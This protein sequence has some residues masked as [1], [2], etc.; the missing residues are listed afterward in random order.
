M[1]ERRSIEG[2][3]ELLARLGA[4]L[5]EDPWR[6]LRGEAARRAL[7]ARAA[8][9]VVLEGALD[10][11][12]TGFALDGVELVGIPAGL[13]GIEGL[14]HRVEGWLRPAGGAGV[15]LEVFA[16]EAMRVSRTTRLAGRDARS[17]RSAV[18]SEHADETQAWVDALQ[19]S[20]DEREAAAFVS[21]TSRDAEE[22]L[23]EVRATWMRFLGVDRAEAPFL[24]WDD[25]PP[26]EAF[27]CE[28]DRRPLDRGFTSLLG[29]IDR[30]LAEANARVP[31]RNGVPL[32]GC[33]LVLDPAA[34][35]LRLIR[36]GTHRVLVVRG[37]HVEIVAWE[38][39]T[40]TTIE[41]AFPP[42]A[43]LFLVARPGGQGDPAALEDAA[44][45][46]DP[47]AL[48]L[49]LA[50][51]SA[52]GKRSPWALFWLGPRAPAI[53]RKRAP[54]P[55]ISVFAKRDA[56]VREGV[57]PK[58][59]GRL[60]PDEA[61]ALR[62]EV[63]ATIEGSYADAGHFEAPRF[64]GIHLDDLRGALPLED[65][66]S[67]RV[68]GW[69][70]PGSPYSYPTMIPHVIEA[71]HPMSRMESE[72]VP[73]S[74]HESAA[75][76]PSMNA[77]PG[78]RRRAHA[79]LRFH[80]ALEAGGRGLQH[81]DFVSARPGGFMVVGLFRGVAPYSGD[82]AADIC[83][84][85]LSTLLDE[86]SY[87]APLAPV[88]EEPPRDH[89]IRNN[90][91]RW[92]A[93]LLDRSPLP[94]EPGRLLEALAA[95]ISAMFTQLNGADQ[96]LLAHA[97]GVLA[98]VSSSRSWII[99]RGLGRVVRVRGRST[100][101]V[102]PESTLATEAVAAGRPV[103]DFMDT[104]AL[105]SFGGELEAQPIAELALEPG[106][107]LVFVGSEGFKLE[108][109]SFF[110]EDDGAPSLLRVRDAIVGAKPDGWAFVAV[111]TGFETQ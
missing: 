16:L 9:P 37:G 29:A 26:P 32:D 66:W 80:S 111:D 42:D 4:R 2:C 92:V 13:E 33:V 12:S 100:S 110:S 85:V 59:A 79:S 18:P 53:D 76:S 51:L 61:H 99:R 60:S 8:A 28:V 52:R 69:V 75:G 90:L 25:A 6:P 108:E 17:Y 34:P 77:L 88:D 94:S 47:E 106:D 23:A 71:L 97:Y 98:C 36:R 3:L 101:L 82:V 49:R 24:L 45:L 30:R 15:A 5:A 31:G 14:R 67:Y 43:T 62:R 39:A 89:G 78:P 55:S 87:G 11:T 7:A 19:G 27:P 56:L 105:S 81:T 65:D 38:P 107:R 63:W 64:E 21:A 93:H 46:A 22:A 95:R 109:S 54:S 44:R 96:G 40:T 83:R 104:I 91:S 70:K 74:R 48:A 50:E 20:F 35:R 103:E 10:R 68:E 72:E 102:V 41:H 57:L 73:A 86:P 84:W 58:G 1:S